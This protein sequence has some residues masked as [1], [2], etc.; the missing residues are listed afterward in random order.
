MTTSSYKKKLCEV[1]TYHKY[2]FISILK[3]SQREKNNL[4]N[5]FEDSFFQVAFI[6]CSYFLEQ[7]FVKSIPLVQ[8]ICPSRYVLL[9]QSLSRRFEKVQ[10]GCVDFLN[11]YVIQKLLMAT[12]IIPVKENIKILRTLVTW[13]Y[14]RQEGD[15]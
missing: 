14:I 8:Q 11:F 9:G 5:M 6:F 4:F 7:N 15:S 2:L 12:P 1:T 10:I 13:K 3:S